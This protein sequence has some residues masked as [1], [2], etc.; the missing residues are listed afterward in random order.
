MDGCRPPCALVHSDHCLSNRKFER[1]GGPLDEINDHFCT[2]IQCHNSTFYY[3]V[4]MS[5]DSRDRLPKRWLLYY[6]WAQ[7]TNYNHIPVVTPWENEAQTE[8]K[9]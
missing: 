2:Q 7:S 1:L 4:M 8:Q 5:F 3:D 6:K 9:H